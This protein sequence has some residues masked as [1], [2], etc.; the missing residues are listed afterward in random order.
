LFLRGRTTSGLEPLDESPEAANG[1]EVF[2][3]VILVSDLN[4]E[5]PLAENAHFD[6][7]DGIEADDGSEAVV[8]TDLFGR[9]FNEQI[10][11]KHLPQDIMYVSF[12][13]SPS[14]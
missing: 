7:S 1:A 4:A 11:H 5:S 3:R 2:R 14:E 13:G 9:Q 12:H 10:V 6:K 8:E